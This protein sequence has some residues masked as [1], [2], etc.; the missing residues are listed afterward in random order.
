MTDQP[1]TMTIRL[2]SLL[3]HYRQYSGLS[4][5]ELAM[6]SGVDQSNISLIETGGT[7]RPWDATLE[8]LAAAM[9]MHIPNGDAQ[10]IADH[11]KEAKRDRPAADYRI[12]PALILLNDR[13]I[14]RPARFVEAALRV[15]NALL[16]AL[17]DVAQE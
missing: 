3:R 12:L 8:S 11:L 14:V 16:D 6:E 17:E 9:A 2:S 13:L 4:Q 1:E 7:T 10:R 15:I 5:R